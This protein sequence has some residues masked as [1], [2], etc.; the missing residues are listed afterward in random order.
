MCFEFVL[1]FSLSGASA[2]GFTRCRCRLRDIAKRCVMLLQSWRQVET[3]LAAVT[4]ADRRSANYNY[5]TMPQ[6][7]TH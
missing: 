2:C 3:P 7:Q 1:S 4:Q 5:L 6:Q